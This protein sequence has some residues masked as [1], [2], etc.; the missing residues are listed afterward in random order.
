MPPGPHSAASW[1]AF[2]VEGL[3]RHFSSSGF[4]PGLP[5]APFGKLQPLAPTVETKFDLQRP[6]LSGLGSIRDFL[7][8]S[9]GHGVISRFCLETRALEAV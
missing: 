2:L 9:G 4:V 3:R 7:C 5:A 8:F 1:D 6:F